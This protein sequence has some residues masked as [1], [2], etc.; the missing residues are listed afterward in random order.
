MY[1][2]YALKQVRFTPLVPAANAILSIIPDKLITSLQ[3]L[4][5]IVGA[6]VCIMVRSFRFSFCTYSQIAHSCCSPFPFQVDVYTRRIQ[7]INRGEIVPAEGELLVCDVTQESRWSGFAIYGSY[8]MLF[9]HFAL[10]R[11]CGFGRKAASDK[12]KSA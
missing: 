5:M 8:F 7:A 9:A 4:Q 2:Y 11:Y 6:T 12:K 1:S 10:K 3:I